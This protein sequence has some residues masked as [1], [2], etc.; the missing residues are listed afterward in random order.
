MH[1]ASDHS[2]P[3]A[4]VNVSNT[5]V[6]LQEKVEKLERELARLKTVNSNG[7]RV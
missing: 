7:P 1:V 2:A 4:V 3:S 5:D 6:T